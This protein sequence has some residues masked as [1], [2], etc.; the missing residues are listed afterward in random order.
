MTEPTI[1]RGASTAIGPQDPAT[2]TLPPLSV[3]ETRSPAPSR[4]PTRPTASPHA[5]IPTGLPYVDALRGGLVRGRVHAIA[6]SSARVR[7]LVALAVAASLARRDVRV[8]VAVPA[9]V[10]LWWRQLLYACAGIDGRR[11]APSSLGDWMHLARAVGE[12]GCLPLTLAE[13][14][15]RKPPRSP[16]DGPTPDVLVVL[17]ASPSD[18]R[19]AETV[20]PTVL[21]TQ[22]TSPRGTEAI[23]LMTLPRRSEPP[24]R[25]VSPRIRRTSKAFSQ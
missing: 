21:V 13:R 25:R 19:L 1:P 12:L 15:A 10:A 22:P 23:P 7:G 6:G 14:P 17:E 5:P 4:H 11:H 9:P 3:S 20:C 2:F 8:H 24:I 18:R 16:D